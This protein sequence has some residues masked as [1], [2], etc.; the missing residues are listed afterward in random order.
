MIDEGK[1][2]DALFWTW[3]AVALMTGMIVGT[4]IVFWLAYAGPGIPI[5][6]PLY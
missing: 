5:S 3:M 6:Q 4:G 1:K 2:H